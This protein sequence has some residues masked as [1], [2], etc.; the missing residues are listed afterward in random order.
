MRESRIVRV[1]KQASS[2][3][4][5]DS[6]LPFLQ[7]GNWHIF[8]LHCSSDLDDEK[9]ADIWRILE[10]N[11]RD[12][13]SAS[14]FGWDPSAKREELFDL[15]SR[16]VLVYHKE[17]PNR[18]AAFT[19]F[20]FEYED[21]KNILYCYE[22]Q[23]SRETQRNGLG[24]KLMTLLEQIALYWKMDKLMLTVFKANRDALK[25]YEAIGFTIDPTSPSQYLLE[26]VDKKESSCYDVD[27]EILSKGC[28]W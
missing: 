17:S 15:S 16:Y 8:Y 4:L 9:R 2:T 22:L 20:R 19:M 28:A 27:Y 10:E 24:K 18:L 3:T 6:C 7:S 12:L 14:S 26:E 13:Y 1:A 23:I 11:M 21:R 25:F 5:S